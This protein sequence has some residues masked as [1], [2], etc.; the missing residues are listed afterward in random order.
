MIFYLN[1]YTIRIQNTKLVTYLLKS[2]YIHLQ[3]YS[4]RNADYSRARIYNIGATS[5][6]HRRRLKTTIG[7]FYKSKQ[8]ESE[9][10]EIR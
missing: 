4:I 1:L 3:L 10:R 9:R 6:Y 5:I 8:G 7:A 2:S